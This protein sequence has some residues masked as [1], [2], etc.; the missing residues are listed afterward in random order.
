[1]GS[2]NDKSEYFI[3]VDL[4]GTKIYAGVFDPG[5]ALVGTT[6][7]STKSDRGHAAVIERLARCVRDAIDECDLSSKN[8]RA[9]GVGAPGTVDGETGRVV[10]APNLGW[11]NVPLQKELQ[12]Q[13]EM[14]VFVGNDCTLGMLGVYA[15]ELKA[16]PSHVIGIFIGT[17]IGGG[18]ILNGEP[19]TGAGHAAGEVGHMVINMGGPKCACG[20]QGCLEAVASRTAIF[21]RVAAAV[22]DGQKTILTDM[23]G[24]ELKDLRSGDLRKAIR[25]GDKL[26]ERVVSDA[27][28]CI[29]IAVGNLINIFS[30][31]IVV[32]GGGVIEALD[33]EMLPTISK[34]A[35]QHVL[36]GT[37][38]S[39]EIIS[40]KLGDHAGIVG[41]A[42][43]AR[44]S[45][46]TL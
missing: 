17:G 20:N 30:P 43:F 33:D 23:L 19:Y 2:T 26:V 42:V 5:L 44:Q 9:V 24:D 32:L 7:L 34:I 39:I 16:K 10:F 3:G 15:Q 6:K 18:L 45:V 46:K 22:K 40:S 8:I 41:A 25:R 13:L 11:Q 21:R 28:D 31:E 36:P 27:A 37:E 29:G 1:M 4:G 12:K 35:R 14:P 38:K